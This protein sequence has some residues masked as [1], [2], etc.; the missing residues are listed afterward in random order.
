VTQPPPEPPDHRIVPA[1][2]SA[3]DADGDP[4]IAYASEIGIEAPWPHHAVCSQCSQPIRCTAPGAAWEHAQMA[5]PARLVTV[6]PN[7]AVAAAAAIR[8]GH[9]HGGPGHDDDDACEELARRLTAG[10]LPPLPPKWATDEE[11]AAYNA[12]MAARGLHGT[13]PDGTCP[14]C[15]LH[16]LDAPERCTGL[17]APGGA[18]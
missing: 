1:P 15:G 3:T 7:T 2:G 12:Q 11:M 6:S 4:V 5:A 13:G 16:F 14:A 17:L 10:D 9:E 8:R 18:S